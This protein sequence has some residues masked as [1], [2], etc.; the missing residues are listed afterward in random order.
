[1]VGDEDQSIYRWRGADYNNVLRF[2]KEYPE[3]RKILLEQNYRSTQTVVSAARAV[4]DRN[5]ARTRKDSSPSARR[6]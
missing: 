3:C 6:G 4:I 5:T 1:M 2:E